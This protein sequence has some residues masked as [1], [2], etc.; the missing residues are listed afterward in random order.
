MY[1]FVYP[2]THCKVSCYLQVLAALIFY[3]LVFKNVFYYLFLRERETDRERERERENMRVH[4]WRGAERDG[5]RSWS[6]LQALSCQHRAR[7]GAQTYQPWDHD[8]SRSRTL[9][10]LSHP[11]APYF[12]FFEEPPYCFPEWLHQ[13]ALPPTMQKDLRD[14]RDEQKG[15]ETKII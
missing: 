5:D 3:F 12:N 7:R 8:L 13:L 4:E 2:F 11:G 9:N 15:R 14:R 10:Q 1:Q 6:R